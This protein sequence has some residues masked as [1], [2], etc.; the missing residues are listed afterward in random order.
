MIYT[1]GLNSAETTTLYPTWIKYSVMSIAVSNLRVR[2]KR[3]IFQD[4]RNGE[5]VNYDSILPAFGLTCGEFSLFQVICENSRRLNK[6][7]SCQKQK[8]TDGKK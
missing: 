6:T 8:K 5:N 2:D 7:T 4:M 1:T 3:Q